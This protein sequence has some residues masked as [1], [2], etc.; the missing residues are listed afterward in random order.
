[1]SRKGCFG[2]SSWNGHFKSIDSATTSI[3]VVKLLELVYPKVYQ[4]TD[5]WRVTLLFDQDSIHVNGILSISRI[6]RQHPSI[7]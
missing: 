4:G 2:F 1:M 3:L 5:H 6:I 7:R